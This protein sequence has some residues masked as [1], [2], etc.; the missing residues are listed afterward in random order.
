M[1]RLYTCILNC[2]QY[3][4]VAVVQALSRVL[5]F[6]TPWTAALSVTVSKSLFRFM[7]LS[8]WC[9]ITISTSA[10]LF[11][12]C[13]QPLPA[14]GSFPISRLFPS[15]GQSIGTSA[16]VLPMSIQGWFPLGLTGLISLQPK[17]LLRVFCSTIIHKHQ[18]I[19]NM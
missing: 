17:G 15:G 8:H 11:S 1:G 13:L 6:V 10:V 3:S 9:Y 16:S 4:S 5:L 2:S 12:Y 18:F 7:S 14:S 19:Q